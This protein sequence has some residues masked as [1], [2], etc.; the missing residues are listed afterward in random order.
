MRALD[1][2]SDFVNDVVQIVMR[3]FNAPKSTIAAYTDIVA[4]AHK[5]FDHEG[6]A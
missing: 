5:R 2:Q 4:L 3:V 6:L 1:R